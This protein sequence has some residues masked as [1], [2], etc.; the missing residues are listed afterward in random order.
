[1]KERYILVEKGNPAFRNINSIVGSINN[2][3]YKII[4][5]LNLKITDRQLP[6]ITLKVCYGN[7]SNTN[8]NEQLLNKRVRVFVHNNDTD[9]LFEH[10][11]QN[12]IDENM[13]ISHIL[14]LLIAYSYK[15]IKISDLSCDAELIIDPSL[16]KCAIIDIILD[17]V[18]F[19][20]Y[21]FL[22][23]L[24]TKDKKEVSAQKYSFFISNNLP[25]FYDAPK[26][27][28]MY[29]SLA[30][31]ARETNEKLNIDNYIK[32]WNSFVCAYYGGKKHREK[33]INEQLKQF[34][35]YDQ[36]PKN[37]YKRFYKK[38]PGAYLVLRTNRD[39]TQDIRPEIFKLFRIKK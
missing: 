34:V 8:E 14:D 35:D 12:E 18:M 30:F 26:D 25:C 37:Y 38:A 39:R 22:K 27:K 17:I 24:N 10:K 16:L 13:D 5:D 7:I 9:F 36:L 23:N 31:S 19:N 15:K 20:S 21:S 4:Q 1:M 29:Y 28:L 33:S 3:L 6:Y 32:Y 2:T 11:I